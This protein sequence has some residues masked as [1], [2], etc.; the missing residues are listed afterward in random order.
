[1]KGKY[2]INIFFSF[3]WKK[4]CI[5]FSENFVWVSYHLIMIWELLNFYGTE[6]T[7]LLLLLFKIAV[8]TTN[9]NKIIINRKF[10]AFKSVNSH[11][12]WPP[13]FS[14]FFLSV[15]F[16]L[17][18]LF[19][20]RVFKKKIHPNTHCHILQTNSDLSIDEWIFMIEPEQNI[21]DYFVRYKNQKN[22][23]MHKKSKFSMIFSLLKE[24]AHRELIN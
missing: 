22:F 24:I 18:F 1:M 20:L 8:K 19:F 10:F 17:S 3:F 14:S 21:L 23:L 13:H 2:Q 16:F 6:F 15:F 9:S 5:Y 12:Q 4:Y 7:L 11:L